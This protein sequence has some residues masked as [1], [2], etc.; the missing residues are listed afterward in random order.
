MKNTILAAVKENQTKN[1]LL[2]NLNFEPTTAQL[3]LKK[4]GFISQ[5]LL[6]LQM[7]KEI[8]SA[9]N[10]SYPTL[11]IGETGTGKELI[12]QALVPAG[13]KMISINC[14]SFMQREN[15]LESEL[16]GYVKGAFTGANNDTAGLVTKANGNV[17]FLDELHQL[18]IGAQAKLLRFLQEMKFRKVGDNSGNETKVNFKLIAAV[19]TDIKER[20]KDKSF[21]TDLYERVG[22]LTINAP[23]LREKPEDTELLVRHFQDEFN[24]DKS[25]NK[26]KQFRISTVTE[27]KKQL[28]PTN[29]RGLQNAVK[30]MMTNCETDIINPVDFKNYLLKNQITKEFDLSNSADET[31][32]HDEAMKAF[33]TQ[34]IIEILKKSKTKIEAAT[35]LGL[36]ITT[37]ARKINV[38][39]ID[40]KFYLASS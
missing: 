32:D 9:K 19:Q 4:N 34:R 16:F 17:L 12:A 33:E 7:L 1:G 18:P 11:I 13:K 24:K 21:L 27:I 8:E 28:W 20:I 5:S 38:L 37:L 14:A 3:E 15:L 10:S 31:I 26:Q 2:K 29:I 23:S 22:T 39:G 30:Q 40:P 25:Q 36:P 6:M 35:R